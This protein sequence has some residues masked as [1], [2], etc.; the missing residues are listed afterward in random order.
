MLRHA[1]TVLAAL[2]II[3]PGTVAAV[4]E[5]TERETLRLVVTDSGMGGLSVVADIARRAEHTKAYRE[6]EVIFVN[7]LFRPEAGYNSLA[8]RD[9][10]VAIFNSALQASKDRYNPDAI[11][12]ACNTL[13]VLLPDCEVAQRGEVPV[14]GIVNVGVEMIEEELKKHPGLTA[15]LFATETTV[16]DG[17]HRDDL[18]ARGI[19]DE[20]IVMQA[21]PELTW[22]I[23][24]DPEGFETELMISAFVSEALEKRGDAEGPVA[25]SFNCTHFGY[26]TRLWEQEIAGQGASLAAT[27]NP[28]DRMA[29][30]LFPEEIAGRF[31]SAEV[32]IRVVSMVEIGVQTVNALSPVLEEVSPAAAAAFRDW[33]LV[34]DLF[35]WERAIKTPAAETSD[36]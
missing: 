22:Y 25:I 5:L 10:Q 24:Q 17:V 14:A 16:E 20:R 29:D 27:L 8:S 15:I 26:S 28:N 36:Q 3:L 6:V 7:A 1:M 21:C 33:E 11:L 31:D 12:V 32:T 18:L 23:E 34:P 9:E 19:A 13:S 35:D 4:P 2:A 30:A